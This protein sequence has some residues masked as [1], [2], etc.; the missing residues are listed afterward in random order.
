MYKDFEGKNFFIIGGG[1]SLNKNIISS[2]PK[3]STICL[4]SSM[5]HLD[6]FFSLFWMDHSWYK[7]PTNKKLMN[8]KKIKH[9][10]FISSNK[11]IYNDTSFTWVKRTHIFC[12]YENDTNDVTVIG[13]NIGACCLHFLDKVKANRVFLLGFDGKHINGKSHSHDQYPVKTGKFTL[14][15]QIVPCFTELKKNLRNIKVYNCYADSAIRCF[16]FISVE[17]ALAKTEER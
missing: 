10:V 7:N 17:K 8:E 5:V 6:E 3:E 12:E 16:P 1:N 11:P 15:N 13:N 2:L 9:R 4:N 14:Q